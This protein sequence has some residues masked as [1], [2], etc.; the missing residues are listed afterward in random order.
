MKAGFIG[1]GKVGFHWVNILQKRHRCDR[2]LQPQRRF[3]HKG[4]GIYGTRYYKDLTDIIED[5][6]GALITEPDGA[7]TEVWEYIRNL[8]IKNKKYM[9]LQRFDLTGRFL[10]PKRRSLPLFHSSLYAF[11]DRYESYKDLRALIFP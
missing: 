4:L 3:G 10:M 5:S 6:D 9:S 11:S 8:P 7:I 2:L 1:A